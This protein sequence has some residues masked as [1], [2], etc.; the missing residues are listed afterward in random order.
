MNEKITVDTYVVWL[1]HLVFQATEPLKKAICERHS[2]DWV[3][4]QSDDSPI[5]FTIREGR[6]IVI[7]NDIEGS[8]LMDDANCIFCNA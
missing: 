4:S 5:R 2:V 1:G 8:F 3:M 7:I 6:F